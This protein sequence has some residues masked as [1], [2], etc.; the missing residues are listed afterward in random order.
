MPNT[1][2]DAAVRDATAAWLAGTGRAAGRLGSRLYEALLVAA[3]DDLRRDGAA[4]ATWTVLA[5]VTP[6]P[7]GSA[8]PL[9][10]MA[11]VHRLVLEGRAPELAAFNPSV[12]GDGDPARAWPA[13][14]ATLLAHA[15]TLPDLIRRPCQTNEVG[16]SA[17]LLGGF[18]VVARATGL[19]L[20]LL[21]VGASAGL[22]V[23][24]DRFRYVQRHG[25]WGPA[26]SPVVLDGDSDLPAE[27]LAQP[28]TVAS[29][30]GCDADPVDPATPEGRLALSAAVWAD[31]TV[32]F[33]RLAGALRIAAEV[34]ARVDAAPVGV[35][36]PARLAEPALGT[37]TVVYH[38][39]VRQYVPEEQRRA[40][41]AALAEAAAR[42]TPDAPLAWLRMEPEHHI[43]SEMDVDLTLWPGGRS[44]RIARV[45][46]HGDP[47]HWLGWPTR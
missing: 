36:L 2:D 40:M 39:V 45:G 31:Q 3:A 28:V 27:L 12:G 43:R 34:P 30:Q 42:A 4:S 17:A 16:R 18:L 6:A 22:N 38:S 35:W 1:P 41:D 8:L 47:V 15:A 24:W 32:R 26:D 33:Q 7:D 20:R 21:E 23:R 13:F 5:P 11:A 29:R 46:A 14:R 44:A 9:R 37:A 25:S 10:F 19:P